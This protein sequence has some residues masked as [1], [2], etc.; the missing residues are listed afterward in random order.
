MKDYYLNAIFNDNRKFFMIDYSITRDLLE[1]V[2]GVVSP[3]STVLK[4]Q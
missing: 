2:E 4:A 3:R 1:L